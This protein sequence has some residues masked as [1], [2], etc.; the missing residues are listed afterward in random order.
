[1]PYGNGVLLHFSGTG[2]MSGHRP[3]ES[4]S[5]HIDSWQDSDDGNQC[6]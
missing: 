1:M 3:D 5:K 4:C 6:N 2:A